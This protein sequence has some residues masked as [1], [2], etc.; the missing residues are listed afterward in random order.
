MKVAVTY[1]FHNCFVLSMPDRVF[2]FDYP[3]NSMLTP[4]ARAK[5][6]E[7]TAGKPLYVFFSHSHGDHFNHRFHELADSPSSARFILAEE[8]RP[9]VNSMP[10]PD[11][12]YMRGGERLELN[13][14]EI[15]SFPSNDLGVAF[16]IQIAGM[17][18][19]YGGDLANWEWDENDEDEARF[20]REIWESTLSILEGCQVDLAFSNADARLANWSGASEFLER[21]KPKGFIPMHTFG[22]PRILRRF[23]RTLQSLEGIFFY[24]REGDAWEI[25]MGEPKTTASPDA[26]GGR[27]VPNRR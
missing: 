17:T 7:L 18:V 22:K 19:Y 13:G 11:V 1:I 20:I 23:A 12:I 27:S 2:L 10:C 4:K 5:V 8:I 15:R 6:Q 26:C 25:E 14:M 3:E 21:V 16:L 9:H 24:E